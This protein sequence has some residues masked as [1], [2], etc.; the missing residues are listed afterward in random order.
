MIYNTEPTELKI[1]NPLPYKNPLPEWGERVLNYIGPRV[2]VDVDQITKSCFSS[3]NRTGRKKL[4]QLALAGYLTR[5]EISTDTDRHF[6]AYTLGLEGMRLKKSYI[7]TV[8]MKKAQEL[9][10]ANAFCRK[11]KIEKFSFAVSKGLLIGQIAIENT[12]YSLWCP[13]QAEKPRRIKSLKSEMPLTSQGIIIVAPNLRYIYSII[14]QVNGINVPVM[15]C[16]DTI[17]DRLMHL[18]NGILVPV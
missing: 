8:D 3:G 16:I 6:I 4:V 5:Y 17:L 9:I 10:I 1:I 14:D 7:P 18:N 12:K 2:M 15:F 13:R 11:H